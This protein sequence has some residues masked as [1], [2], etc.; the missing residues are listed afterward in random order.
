MP[1]DEKR[2]PPRKSYASPSLTMFGTV[3]ELTTSGSEPGREH[4]G[5]GNR[6]KRA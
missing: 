3:A 4:G 6:D 1:E 2:E 5:V